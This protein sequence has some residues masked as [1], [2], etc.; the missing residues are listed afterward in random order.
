MSYS[1][2]RVRTQRVDFQ[3]SGI[4]GQPSNNDW[5]I[6]VDSDN[7]L[8]QYY[9]ASYYDPGT[10]VTGAF[11]TRQQFAAGTVGNVNVT[12]PET[13]SYNITGKLN[14]SDDLYIEEFT[15]AQKLLFRYLTPLKFPGVPVVLSNLEVHEVPSGEESIVPSVPTA[16]NFTDSALLSVVVVSSSISPQEMIVR[17]KRDMRIMYK[18]LFIFL[19]HQ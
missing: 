2:G 10:G 3:G 18:T 13:S 12:V 16:T 19:F 11:I 9:N 6:L 17:L 7:L 8:F 14:V 1:L 15:T 4:G 5:R